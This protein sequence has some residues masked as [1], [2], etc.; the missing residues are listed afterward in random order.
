MTRS[1]T[2]VLNMHKE[3]QQQTKTLPIYVAG[4]THVNTILIDL[5][6]GTANDAFAIPDGASVYIRLK[7]TNAAHSM[8]YE[9]DVLAADEGQAGLTLTGAFNTL[10]EYTGTVYLKLGA[11]TM[12]C[13][14]RLT[15]NVVSG[16]PS[17]D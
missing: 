15:F 2:F 6:D 10:N 12:T 4:D 13:L 3:T 17:I 1:R 8:E 5:R 16:I 14:Q 9:M 7:P 11:E